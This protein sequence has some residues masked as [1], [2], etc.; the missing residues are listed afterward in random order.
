MVG[1]I[2]F[3]DAGLIGSVLMLVAHGFI[4]PFLFFRLNYIYEVFHSRRIF[5]LKGVI[6]FI[7]I[8]CFFWFIGVILNIGFPPFISFF[9]EIII[10]MGLRFLGLLD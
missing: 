4:S 9:S 5:I 10:S 2:S 8:F 6:L 1:F 7:P 3:T